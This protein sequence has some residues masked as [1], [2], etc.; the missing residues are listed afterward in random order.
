MEAVPSNIKQIID[1]L[2]QKEKPL[3]RA[4]LAD[5]SNLSTEELAYLGQIWATIEVDRRSKIVDRLVELTEENFELNFDSIFKVGLKDADPEVRTKSIEGLWENEETSLISP[6]IK[7]LNEDQSEEVQAASAKALS[8]YAM[9]A[10]LKRLGPYSSG[11]VSQALLAILAD[12]AK[13]AEVWRRALEA[14]APLSLPE[15]KK[16]IAE[17]YQSNEPKIKN[18][19]I[20]AMGKNYDA[21][22]LPTIIKELSSLRAD[23]RYE[24]AGACG[25]ICD[26]EAVPHLFKLTADADVDVQRAAISAL[27]SIGGNKAKQI[28]LKLSKSSDEIVSEAAE[29]ALKQIE[30]EQDSFAF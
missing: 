22:W 26:E 23:T 10:E 1:D 15:V 9:L 29:Q 20:F 4:D 7:M 3:L 5:L 17:A 24:A 2:A 11:R 19:A 8:K 12:K 27:G 16:A 21:T 14:A 25:E 18:S 6:L 28:L 13:P 30:A